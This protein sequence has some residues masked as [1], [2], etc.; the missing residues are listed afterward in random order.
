MMRHSALFLVAALLPWSPATARPLAITPQ[1]VEALGIRTAPV[2]PAATQ[3]TVSVLGRIA[4]APD[5]RIP[6]SAPFAG[7]VVQLLRLEGESVQ[8]G[9]PLA[10]IVSADMHAALAKLKGQEAHYRSAKAAADR[11]QALVSE[12]IAPASRAEEANAE[13]SAAAAELAASRNVMSRAGDSTS[14]GY[15]LLAPAKGRITSIEVSAGDQVAAMQPMLSIDTR[16]E[17]W[18]EGTLPASAIGQVVAGDSVLLEGMPGVTGIVTA[19]GTSIDP[20]TRAATVRAR[21]NASTSLVSGQTVRLSI[22]RKAQAGSFQVPRVAIAELKSG[23]VVFAARK[24]GFEPVAIQ[25]L[26]RG[27]QDVTIKGPIK[28]GDRVAISGVSEL[29]AANIQD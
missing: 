20:K 24:D 27:A 18:V 25:V 23:P 17:L 22:L 13:A 26:A 6:V 12:G 16:T 5:S 19:A 21:L 3:T 29:K 1:Q 14:G 7:A 2:R 15:R 10:V 11:A 28:P 4:P 9:D 8:K